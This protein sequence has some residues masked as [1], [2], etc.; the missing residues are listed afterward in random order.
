M[1]IRPCASACAVAAGVAMRQLQSALQKHDIVH[2]T[3]PECGAPMWLTRFGRRMGLAGSSTPLNAKPAK[4][5]QL[6]SYGA[7]A[8][9]MQ[10]EPQKGIRFSTTAGQLLLLVAAVMVLN[11]AWRY[12]L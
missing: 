12:V 10:N 3:C 9:T 6:I 7:T 8:M 11:L 4:T 2:P 1:I 5:K